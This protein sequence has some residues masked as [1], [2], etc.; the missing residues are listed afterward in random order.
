MTHTVLSPLMATLRDLFHDKIE[1][2]RIEFIRLLLKVKHIRVFK[3]G[4]VLTSIA[5]NV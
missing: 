1:K 4:L 3:V 5:S 2:V